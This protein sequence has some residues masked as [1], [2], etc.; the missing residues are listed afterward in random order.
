MAQELPVAPAPAPR[1]DRKRSAR[2][3]RTDD[4]AADADGGRDV[5]DELDRVAAAPASKKRAVKAT[6]K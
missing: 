2:Q 6:A 4:D 1:E 3:D 5:W